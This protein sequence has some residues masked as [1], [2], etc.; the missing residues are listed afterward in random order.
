MI[1]RPRQTLSIQLRRVIGGLA[2]D[3]GTA[4]LL[5]HRAYGDR[6][7]EEDYP[8]AVGEALYHNVHGAYFLLT[9]NECVDPWEDGYRKIVP[10]TQTQAIIWA[11][12]NCPHLVEELFGRM[13]EAGEGP[14]YT[15]RE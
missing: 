14:P 3:T 12:V 7:D 13:P 10:L 5:Y 9:Y 8:G 6:P 2:Y 4:S 15:P 11:E 1:T